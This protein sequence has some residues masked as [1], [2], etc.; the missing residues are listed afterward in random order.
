MTVLVACVHRL[1]S[2]AIPI[3][4]MARLVLTIMS[5]RP[6][7]AIL[8]RNVAHHCKTR[9]R[10]ALH[11]IVA[12]ASVVLQES[13]D[14]EVLEQPVPML[15]NVSVVYAKLIPSC[16]EASA[17]SR[18]EIN[19]LET[20][21][22]RHFVTLNHDAGPLPMAKLV[23]LTKIVS[24]TTVLRAKSVTGSIRRTHSRVRTTSNVRLSTAIDRTNVA[25]P[26][27]APYAASLKTAHL[28][29]AIRRVFVVLPSMDRVVRTRPSVREA[30]AT[31]TYVQAY[32]ILP[33]KRAIPTTNVQMVSVIPSSDVA[34]YPMVKAVYRQQT[35]LR[36]F[37][38][39]S[40]SVGRVSMAMRAQ[41]PQIAQAITACLA[42]ALPNHWSMDSRVVQPVNALPTFASM[43]N[44]EKQPSE[45]R[46]H[47]HRSVHK[48][49]VYSQNVAL[50]Y[51]PAVKPAAHQL[52]VY[53][54]HA[55]LKTYA[56]YLLMVTPALLIVSAL[57]VYAI[58]RRNA[59]NRAMV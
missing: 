15:E 33:A 12:A 32:H 24:A 22:A 54:L 16:L 18:M 42:P 41:S 20:L 7:I 58:L 9:K 46:V 10:A 26:R 6:V 49:T 45:R 31:Q 43:E 35:A 11:E 37:A 29:F 44:A 36:H 27:M 14:K 17:S 48:G 59:E 57:L 19:V 51:L 1:V 13:A 38:A 8:A 21:I 30:T 39:G 56:N 53:Q 50:L 47:R 23:L 34:N 4:L 2:V 52:I 28:A 25:V 55:T 40:T 5:V 3:S